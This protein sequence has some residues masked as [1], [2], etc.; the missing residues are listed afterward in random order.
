MD[1]KKELIYIT[2]NDEISI[3][4]DRAYKDNKSLYNYKITSLI[5]SGNDYKPTQQNKTLKW[6]EL[7]KKIEEQDQVYVK[8][9]YYSKT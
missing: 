6:K 3:T 5:S 4:Y 2:T 8:D 1:N 7:Q 9:K